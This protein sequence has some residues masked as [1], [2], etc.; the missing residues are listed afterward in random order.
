MTHAR[1]HNWIILAFSAAIALLSYRF[2]AL[3]LDV[4]FESIPEHLSERR[5]WFG[6]HISAAPVALLL[7][8]VQFFPR[9][10]G[11]FPTAHVW[12]GRTYFAAILLAGVAGLVLAMGATER[13]MAVLGFVL[14]SGLWIVFTTRAV[15]H[16]IRGEVA[17]HRR[18]MTRSFALTFAAVTLRVEIP[19]LMVLGYENYA[20]MS[21]VLAWA[22][23][24]PN[25]LLA[26]WII[27]RA[28]RAAEAKA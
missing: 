10:R 18:W 7:G 28:Q 1:P 11:M 17:A 13:P 6:L 22:C 2:L 23:W 5:N 27:R 24:V 12:I 8:A 3:G 25:L 4:A 15:R 26:E 14:L 19:L 21:P 20:Q 16:A 9:L